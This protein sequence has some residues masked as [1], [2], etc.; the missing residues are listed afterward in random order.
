MRFWEKQA[1]NLRWMK[2]WRKAHEWKLPYAKWFIGGKLNASDNCLDRHVEGPRRTK[3]ALIWEGEPGDTR[4]LTYYDLYREVNR[5]AAALRQHGVKKGDTVTIYM[6]MIPE[7]VVAML[8]CARIGAPH[9]VVF[10]GFSPES[11]RDRINDAKS[12]VLITADGGYR[13]GGT[14]PLKRNADEALKE[15]PT[16]T[17]VIVARRTGQDDRL[18]ERPRY[19]VGRLRQGSAGVLQAGADGLPRTCCT[20]STRRG[21]PASPRASC[22]RPAGTSRASRPPTP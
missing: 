11:L 18:A 12:R 5:F 7:V 8:A 13:R 17:T 3:A 21:P 4:T 14:V 6:P 10:G 19:L 20:S 16:V 15:C 22:T 2:P 1:K 9:S